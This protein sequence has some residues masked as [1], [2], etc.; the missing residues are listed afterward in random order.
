MAMLID[1]IDGKA[2]VQVKVPVCITIQMDDADAKDM[3]Q[4]ELA[5]LVDEII[6]QIQRQCGVLS[7]EF[8]P[9]RW[10]MKIPLRF[11]VAR[12]WDELPIDEMEVMYSEDDY[13]EK[14]GDE[15]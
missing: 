1:D 4:D 6:D 9:R 7:V 11:A 13:F 15:E 14:R 10:M 12:A 8:E 3:T 5:G 2:I